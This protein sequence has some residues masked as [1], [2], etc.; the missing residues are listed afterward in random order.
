MRMMTIKKIIAAFKLTWMSR[1]AM[2]SRER[3]TTSVDRGGSKLL[4][5]GA[6]LMTEMVMLDGVEWICLMV[7]K[8]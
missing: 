8:C 1:L 6:I 2:E 5:M 7:W 3:T 4:V